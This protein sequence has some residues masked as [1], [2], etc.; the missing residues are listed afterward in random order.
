MTS[1]EKQ[2]AHWLKTKKAVLGQAMEKGGTAGLGDLHTYAE[3]HW[4][5]AHQQFSMMMEECVDEE[6]VTFE[7]GEFTVTEKG[8]GFAGEP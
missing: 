8:R 1:E 5:I 4:F 7:D 3:S 6:L 2:K